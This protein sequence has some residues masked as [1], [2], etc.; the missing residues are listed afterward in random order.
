M[1]K[2]MQ[3]A[4]LIGMNLF[5]AFLVSLGYYVSRVSPSETLVAGAAIATGF[6]LM[7]ASLIINVRNEVKANEV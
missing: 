5:G 1:K 4:L 7:I 3:K 2:F 6:C